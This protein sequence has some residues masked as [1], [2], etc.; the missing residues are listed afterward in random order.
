MKRIWWR[1]PRSESRRSWRRRAKAGNA[2]LTVPNSTMTFSCCGNGQYHNL[3]EANG[4]APKERP[5]ASSDRAYGDPVWISLQ[6]EICR[7]QG[8]TGTLL[9]RGPVHR[10]RTLSGGVACDPMPRASALEE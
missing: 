2:E 5:S 4:Q 1:H 7:R 9:L 10:Q 6:A 3:L 8:A